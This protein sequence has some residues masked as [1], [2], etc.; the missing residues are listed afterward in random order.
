MLAA[1]EAEGEGL[2]TSKGEAVTGDALNMPYEDATFDLVLI[3]EVLERIGW[4]R[5]HV[6]NDQQRVR[7]IVLCERAPEKLGYAASAVADTI[8]FKTYRV[9]LTFEDLAI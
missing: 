2:P 6:G 8:R 1:M 5:K 9:A 3:S 7:G 4:V